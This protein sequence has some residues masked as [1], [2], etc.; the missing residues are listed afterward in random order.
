MTS[1][2]IKAILDDEWIEDHD[3][4]VRYV[5]SRR[6]AGGHNAR[7]GVAIINE[8][9]DAPIVARLVA[10]APRLY[11]ACIAVWTDANAK[12][13]Y[14]QLDPAVRRLLQ[15]AVRGMDEAPE[16]ES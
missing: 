2:D 8:R 14:A 3:Q 13:V 9:A 10:R 12:G 15:S 11:Q 6:A 16:V 1:D 4:H 7:H 5:R